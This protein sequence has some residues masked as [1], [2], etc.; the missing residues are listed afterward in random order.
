LQ[1]DKKITPEPGEVRFVACHEANKSH[2]PRPKDK[3]GQTDLRDS[4]RLDG[5]RPKDKPG[6]TDLRDS[7][8]LGKLAGARPKDKQVQTD[9]TDSKGRRSESCEVIRGDV[10]NNET[11]GRRDSNVFNCVIQQ[12]RPIDFSA[13]TNIIVEL[14]APEKLPLERVTPEE[15]VHY[16]GYFASS[17][18]IDSVRTS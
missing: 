9:K 8:V 10:D 16:P 3:R 2:G 13:G 1:D 15:Y 12:L 17:A 14:E 5:T 11:N 6:Q 7:C 18:N 4:F